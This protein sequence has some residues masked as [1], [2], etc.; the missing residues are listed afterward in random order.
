MSGSIS[1]QNAIQAVI[2]GTYVEPMNY[3]DNPVTEFYGCNV[4]TDEVMK[5]RLPKNTYKSVKATIDAGSD[6]DLAAADVVA[7]AMKDWALEKG[8]THYTHVF[9]PLT[10]SSAEK[11]DSF[12]SPD[13]EGKCITEFS[14]KLLVQGEPDASS[15]PNGGIR[16]T[17]EARGYTAWDV[18]SPAYILESDNGTT[19]CIPTCFVSWTG[20]ALDKKTPVLR[21][22]QAVDKAA[23]KVL[24]ILNPGEEVTKVTS[25]AGPEQEYF[26]VD[27]NFFYARPD[28]ISADR[29]VFGAAPVKG[30]EFDDHYF[31]A[32][33][34]RVLNFMMEV[35]QECFKLAIPVKTRHNE[36][37]PGQFEIA[38]VYETANVATDHQQLIVHIIK[39]TANKHGMTAI[40]HEKPFAGLN[41]SGKHLNWSIGNTTQGNLLDPGK[42]P[43]DNLQ[44]I[45]FCAAVISSVEKNQGLLRAVIASAS[46][47]HRLGANEAPPAI[48][49]VFLGDQLADVFAQIQST[50]KATTSID[51]GLMNLGV[52]SMPQLP[53][54]AGDRN[55]TSPFAFTGNRFEFRAVGS[56]Q[57]IAG[58]LVALNTM[59]ADALSSIGSSLEAKIAAGSSIEDAVFATVKDVM[60]ESGQIVFNG[61]GYS[62]EWQVEAAKRGLKNLKTSAEAL[63]EITTPEN[64][65]MFEKQG[66]LSKV[67]LESRQNIYQEQ[68]AAKV[69][70]EANLT[71]RM[72]E[73]QILPAAVRYQ[74]E[75]A[76]NIAS[77]SA[78]G[79]E[80]DKSALVAVTGQIAAL[81]SAVAKLKEIRSKHIEDATEECVYYAHTILPAMLEVRAAADALEASIADDLWPLP[82]YTEMLFI[83]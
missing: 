23:H 49:S 4:F 77:L 33:P 16:D 12:L 5:A 34:A 55:R 7:T 3:I 40:F 47:D 38:P 79:V 73:T 30:Q 65:A 31:G 26:L 32:V 6:L 17:F 53:R 66:V 61:N 29:T 42:T 21:S 28:L 18:T 46:N 14:G 72:A 59:M 74:T 9:Y 36:V 54:D 20:E 35:E 58:P 15:F 27:T 11:H 50:G 39:A 48:L 13:G 60:D 56:L 75:L 70:V 68:Y 2:D 69:N 19:L 45:T 82:N 44:F 57:S 76:E 78:A 81:S 41:G 62:D 80:G 37:A 52:D 22:M 83:K 8:A 25:F 51:G 43:H 10:G 67:E 24:E 71:E 1:R 64:V 63:T